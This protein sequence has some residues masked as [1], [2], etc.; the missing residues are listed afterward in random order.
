MFWEICEGIRKYVKMTLIPSMRNLFSSIRSLIGMFIVM[1]ILQM[2]LSVICIFGIE[3]IKNSQAVLTDFNQA[4]SGISDSIEGNVGSFITSDTFTTALSST[5]IFIGALILWGICA[6]T[7][8]QKVTF[9]SADRDKYI[10]GMYVTHGARKKKIKAMLKCE[11]YVP[12]LLATV[13][14]YPLALA[15]CNYSLRDHGYEYSHSFI[16]IVAIL[17]IS[18]LCIRLVVEYE[19]FLIRSMS[20]TEMLREE[21]SPKSVCY[22]RKNSRLVKGFTAFRYGSSTFMRMRKYYISLALIAAIPAVIWV[23][24]YVSATGEDSYLSSAI[25]EFSVKM[26]VG[27]S[28]DKLNDIRNGDLNEIDGISGIEAK[29]VYDADKIY[30]HILADKE[31]FSTVMNSPYYTTSYADNTVTLCVPNRALKQSI[32]YN[33]ASVKEGTVAMICPSDNAKY[34]LAEG[35]RLFIAV[36]KL[37]GSVRAIDA[38]ALSLLEGDLESEYEYMELEVASVTALR[39]QHLSQDGFLNIDDTYFLLN[40]DDYEKIT[41][42]STEKLISYVGMDKVTYDKALAADGSFNISVPA[43]SLSTVPSVGDCVDITGK[44][45][46]NVR[47]EGVPFGDTTRTLEKKVSNSVSYAYINSVSRSG[48]RVILNVTPYD[49]IVLEHGLGAL[50]STVL[51]LGT[52]ALDNTDTAFFAGSCGDALTLS[53]GKIELSDI[54][55]QICASSEVSAAEA[56]THIIFSEKNLTETAGRLKLETLYADNSFELICAD[57]TTLGKTELDVEP[58][59]KDSNGAVLVLPSSAANYLSFDVGDKL[60]LAVTLEDVIH[61]SEDGYLPK[62][63]YDILEQHVKSNQYDYVVVFIDEV[64]YSDTAE[65]PQ[66]LLGADAFSRVINKKAPYVSFDVIIDAGI[67]SHDYAKMRE[68]LNEWATDQTFVPKLSSTGNYLEY[69]L[70]KNANY[71]TIIMLISIIVPLIVP[72]IW[73]YPIATL[74]DRRKSE[75]Y[76]LRAM[77]KSKGTLLRCFITEGAL[78]SIASFLTVMLLCYP[79]M[80][81]FKSV[82]TLCKL[83]LEFDYSYL[84]L[85]ALLAAGMFSALCAA[86]SFAICYMTTAKG[87]SKK[88]RRKYGNT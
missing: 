60:R 79:A 43:E 68:E 62:G 88:P 74:F 38:N 17:V 63:S 77:G 15:L 1:L 12:H 27:I 23:C 41:S 61:Y 7:V 66:V 36:S 71:S 46:L 84:S 72:F 54:S 58:I 67:E 78:V 24:F 87:R 49:V 19:C 85:P 56:A 48:D 33:M 34:A 39:S 57:E 45:S 51:A 83:P 10:W 35:D 6:I 14:G 76:V 50:P 26:N 32:G 47:L 18:Y 64:I 28:E 75:L 16:N 8:Y 86:V 13:L 21:D 82:C 9:A 11:L 29:A 65:K 31:H 3:N 70:R 69:L 73:Y 30:T 4:L 52:P 37:D 22:P 42:L 59:K 40:S 44:Y 80:F 53:D 55:I 2:L 20:C 5:S 25:N 81:V